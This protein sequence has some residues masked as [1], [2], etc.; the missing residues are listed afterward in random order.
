M[1]TPIYAWYQ[2]HLDYAEIKFL[3]TISTP[4]LTLDNF[5]LFNTTVP[6]SPVEI[7]TPFKEIDIARDYY[8]ISRTFNLW[9][10]VNLL[11]NN[12]YEIRISGLKTVIG[13]VISSDVLDFSVGSL[14]ELTSVEQP[15]KDVS[16]GDV[17]DYSI[18]D[19][20]SFFSPFLVSDT[21]AISVI[22]VK[23]DLN[24]SYYLAESYNEGRIE[25][26][27]NTIPAANFISGDYF[28]VERKPIVNTI[29]RWEK[30]NT[31]VASNPETALVVI[32]MPSNDATPV[33]GE[34]DVT[35]WEPGYKYR[36]RI[37]AQIGI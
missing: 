33:Y 13:E 14:T 31:I 27:F 17:E 15:T 6:E 35:Y 28:K 18:K 7:S 32:Y 3:D 12:D 24:T 2:I 21:T 29:T 5:S 26:T 8:S 9:F 25:I 23:P 16:V 22:S 36:L 10:N 37:S 1:T 30:V 11:A 20:S 4:T 34:P 19:V